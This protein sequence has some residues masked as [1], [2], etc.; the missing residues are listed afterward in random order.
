MVKSKN[1]NIL[2]LE[3]IHTYYGRSHIIQGL[4]MQIEDR[5][6]VSILGRNGV[7]KTTTMRSIMGLTPPSSGQIVINGQVTSKWPPHRI[8]KLGVAYV[9]ADRDIFPGLNVEENLQIAARGKGNG[10]WTLESIYEHFPLLKERCRQDGSTLSGGEQ[11]ILAI[12]RALMSNPNIIMLDEP[13]QG[14]SPFMIKKVA[15]IILYCIDCGITLLV[16]EQNYHLAL[17]IA[18]RHYLMTNKGL[19]SRT[20]TSM[21]LIDKPDIIQSHLSV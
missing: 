7:G 6:S 14:L 17:Q 20:A 21:E 18:S 5:E 12:A 1:N 9:P 15:E 11:Q 3:D 2:E 16:V 10:G 8:A 13:S 4:S 19:I